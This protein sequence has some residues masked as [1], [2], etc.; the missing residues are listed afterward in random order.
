MSRVAGSQVVLGF[1]ASIAIASA[2]EQPIAASKLLLRR[3]ASGSEKLT[4]VSKDPLFLFPALGGPDDPSSGALVVELFAPSTPGGVALDAPSGVGI[5]GWSV[6]T[7]TPPRLQF[8]NPAAPDA[9]SSFRSITLREGKVLKLNGRASGLDVAAPLGAV[10]IRITTGSLVNCALFGPT[11]VR[12]DANGTFSARNA[13]RSALA[14]CSDASLASGVTTTTTSTTTSTTAPVCG[15]DVRNPPGEQCDGTDFSSCEGL[16]CGPPGYST[17]C[18]CCGMGQVPTFPS[19]APCCDPAATEVFFPSIALCI[20]RD[21]SGPFP[22]SLGIC[23][24]G[25]CCAPN[26]A[27]C[28]VRGGGGSAAGVPCC[29][30]AAFCVEFGFNDNACCVGNGAGCIQDGECCSRHC[31]S[32][33]CSSP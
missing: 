27:M 25:S 6:R 32:G 31:A 17:A 3:S 30:P 20:S 12:K 21:C 2:A 11:T 33:I 10:G 1:M 23:V 19:P 4:F 26:G 13:L 28:V 8:R 22:C 7:S 14:D 18:Q 24:D 9:V 29:D 5:P 16:E 15:D